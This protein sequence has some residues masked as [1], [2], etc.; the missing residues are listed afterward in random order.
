MSAQ[1][2]FTPGVRAVAPASRNAGKRVKCRA[3]AAGVAPAGSITN[4]TGFRK[5]S[6]VD[7][8]QAGRGRQSFHAVVAGQKALA[9]NGKGSRM[10][11]SAMFEVRSLATTT[12]SVQTL[13]I[14]HHPRDLPPPPATPPLVPPQHLPATRYSSTPVTARPR[15]T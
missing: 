3:A 10:V 6:V 5:S 2:A 4:M 15:H 7:V 14:L 9:G 1:A 11:A 13:P 12:I 8:V